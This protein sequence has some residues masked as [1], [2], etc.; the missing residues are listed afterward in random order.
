MQASLVIRYV[1]LSSRPPPVCSGRNLSLPIAFFFP[2]FLPPIRPFHGM[3]RDPLRPKTVLRAEL[4]PGGRM[5]C[6][7]I[8]IMTN[9]YISRRKT[10]QRWDPKRGDDGM[11]VVLR[12]FIPNLP[13]SALEYSFIIR[14]FQAPRYMPR[15]ARRGE[16][17]L[18]ILSFSWC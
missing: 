16:Q 11:L 1:R 15:L 8:S 12:Y 18:A 9:R 2:P 7:D 17:R 4:Q 3:N 13:L 5:T 6:R 10:K 14:F